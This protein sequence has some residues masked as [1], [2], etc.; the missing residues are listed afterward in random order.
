MTMKPTQRHGSSE[1]S[2]MSDWE[3]EGG[4]V[5]VIRKTRLKNIKNSPVPGDDT[6]GSLRA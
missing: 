5:P 2:A 6:C 3:N 4:A 1:V